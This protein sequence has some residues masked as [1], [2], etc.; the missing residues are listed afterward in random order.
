MNVNLFFIPCA[1][2]VHDYQFGRIKGA[3]LYACVNRFL[4]GNNAS[5][6]ESQSMS[7]KNFPPMISIKGPKGQILCPKLY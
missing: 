1:Y 4:G 2:P 5:E 3:D 6:G 7:E